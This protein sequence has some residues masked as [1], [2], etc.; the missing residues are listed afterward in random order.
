LSRSVRAGIT[1]GSTDDDTTLV[2]SQQ[3]N[4]L[5]NPDILGLITTAG[6]PRIMQFAITYRF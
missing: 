6:P 5:N 1:H 3:D 4:Q 2:G